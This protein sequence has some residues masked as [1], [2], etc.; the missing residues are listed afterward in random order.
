MED[1][2][3]MNGRRLE[4]YW[5]IRESVR[6]NYRPVAAIINVMCQLFMM[7]VRERIN[8]WVEGSGM[9]GDIHGGFRGG[10]GQKIICLC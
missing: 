6:R 1:A 5:C 7:L 8:E 2:Y 10:E 9:L 3:Q 4:L